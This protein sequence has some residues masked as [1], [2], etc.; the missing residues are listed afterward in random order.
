MPNHRPLYSLAVIA[1]TAKADGAGARLHGGVHLPEKQRYAR[2]RET[3]FQQFN[4]MHDASEPQTA[5]VSR[6]QG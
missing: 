1:V 6:W 4:F 2:C 3:K 5:T